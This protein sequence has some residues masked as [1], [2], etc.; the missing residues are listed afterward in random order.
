MTD[1]KAEA[2]Q[3][4]IWYSEGEITSPNSLALSYYSESAGAVGLYGI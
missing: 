1:T 2:I 4:A 3:Q